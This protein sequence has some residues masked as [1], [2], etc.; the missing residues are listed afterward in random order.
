MTVSPQITFLI[1]L[2][3]GIAIGVLAT[4]IVGFIQHQREVRDAEKN[5]DP[6]LVSR[7]AELMIER[8]RIKELEK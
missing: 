3:F 5:L 7:V 1:V 8:A 4:L 6:E 2:L